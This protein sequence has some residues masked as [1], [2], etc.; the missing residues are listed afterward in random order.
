MVAKMIQRKFL[1]NLGVLMEVI[2][3]VLLVIMRWMWKMVVE[4]TEAVL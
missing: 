2:I 3:F 1:T 4:V